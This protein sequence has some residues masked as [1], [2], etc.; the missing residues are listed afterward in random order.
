MYQDHYSK[1]DDDF[2][3]IHDRDLQKLLIE[4]KLAPEIMHGVFVITECPYP[5]RHELKFKSR[6]IPTARYRTDTAAFFGSR[7]WSHMPN[8]LKEIM[9][10]N[11]LRS[12]TKLG[13]QKTARS[14]FVKSIFRESVTWKLLISIW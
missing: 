8:E 9:L 7:I 6:N 3:K 2:F 5:L 1:S 12:K 11:G 10:L 14:N 13:S 4:M